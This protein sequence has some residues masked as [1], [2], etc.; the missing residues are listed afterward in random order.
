MTSHH[1]KR[2]A[3]IY[4]RTRRFR[5]YCP[6]L[7][8][9][10]VQT[11]SHTDTILRAIMRRRAIPDDIDEA[12][13]VRMQRQRYLRGDRRYSIIVEESALRCG[14][15]SADVWSGQLGHLLRVSTLPSV[16]LGVIPFGVGR[17]AAWPVESFYMFDDAEVNVEL[18][19]GYLTVTQ[20]REIGLY[21][22]AFSE[23]A[24]LAV[25]GARARNLI[26]EAVEATAM[27]DGEQT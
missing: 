18:V 10:I 11:E 6:S 16:S 8:P 13:A 26:S 24:A 5:F 22:Q 23:L 21:A 1:S 3:P 9:G 15:G 12:V 4:E 25:F 20:P 17:E 2:A 27:G 7:L 14:I 19:A